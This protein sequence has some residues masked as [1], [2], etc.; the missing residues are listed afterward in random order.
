RQAGIVVFE[1]IFFLFF[2]ALTITFLTPFL[3]VSPDS[4][5]SLVLRTAWQISAGCC[6]GVV[7]L[8]GLFYYRPTMKL[9]SPW[10]HILRGYLGRFRSFERIF[11]QELDSLTTLVSDLS[12]RKI[13]FGLLLPASLLSLLILVVNALGSWFIFR[14]IGWPLSFVLHLF[15]MPVMMFLLAMPITFATLGVRE[16][17]FVLLYGFFG[18]PAEPAL[19]AAFFSLL[20]FWVSILIGGLL[21]LLQGQIK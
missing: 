3:P 1:K 17:S 16:G 10:P 14:A 4:V 13:M 2:C 20:V 7:L 8:A 12:W 21:L 6:L 18:V 5:L 9:L 15:I 19:L 11:T